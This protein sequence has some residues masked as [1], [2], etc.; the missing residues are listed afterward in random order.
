MFSDVNVVFA[1][2][3]DDVVVVVISLDVIVVCVLF[4]LFSLMCSL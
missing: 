4:S 1:V 2:V 3:I